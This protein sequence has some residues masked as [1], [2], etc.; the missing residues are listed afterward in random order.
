MWFVA[1]FACPQAAAVKD[2]VGDAHFF[3][4]SVTVRALL[5]ARTHWDPAWLCCLR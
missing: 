2:L 4:E 1:L 3:E 5:Y